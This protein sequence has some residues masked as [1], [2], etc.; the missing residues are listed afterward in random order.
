M[1]CYCSP[2]LVTKLS[3]SWRRLCHLLGAIDRTIDLVFQDLCRVYST[4]DRPYHNLTHIDR[5]LKLIG[6]CKA[7]E[8]DRESLQFVAWF[9]D[10]I[11]NPKASDNEAKSGEYA[12]IKLAELGINPE[13]IDRVVSLILYTQLHQAPTD[14][15]EAQILLDADLAI[16]GSEPSDYQTYALA[17]RREYAWLSES[18]YHAG[19]R[20][21]LEQFLQ[22]DRLYCLELYYAKFERQAR[23][24]IH[25]ELVNLDRS[26]SIELKT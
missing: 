26:H 17:I 10:A 7:S 15:L 13:K 2:D 3:E 16:F 12:A 4:D 9:H 24:N 19:R 22:R 6:E 21:V 8:I 20:R 1:R 11:Y 5:V 18:E 23:E 14:D 25:L